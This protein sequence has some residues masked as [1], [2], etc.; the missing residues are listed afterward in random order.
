MFYGRVGPYRG[1]LMAGSWQ[2]RGRLMAGSWQAHGRLMAG[3]ARWPYSV[4]SDHT[5]GRT[6]NEIRIS[7]QSPDF[8]TVPGRRTDRY[9][10]ETDM[11][12]PVT[13]TDH[14]YL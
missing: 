4:I 10:V 5:T 3:L 7:T 12:P 9:L 13:L 6:F 11:V 1:R 14:N 8:F 2:A